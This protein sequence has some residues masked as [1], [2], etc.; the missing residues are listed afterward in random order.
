MYHKC[1]SLDIVR[2]D[3][4]KPIRPSL[5]TGYDKWNQEGWRGVV[6]V[7]KSAPDPAVT[8]VASQLL[9]AAQKYASD[10]PLGAT[11]CVRTK[12]D[13][14]S[15]TFW[16]ACKHAQVTTATVNDNATGTRRGEVVLPIV[17][18]V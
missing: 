12:K 2:H 5:Q 14:G 1:T 10:L 4:T 6:Q 18:Y 7:P 9:D 11:L 17:W 13:D 16:L 8:R 3:P 15:V